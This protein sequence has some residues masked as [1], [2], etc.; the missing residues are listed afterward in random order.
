MP[1]CQT[2]PWLWGTRQ[3]KSQKFFNHVFRPLKAAYSSFMNY[4]SRSSHPFHLIGHL[5]VVLLNYQIIVK[6]LLGKVSNHHILKTRPPNYK[7]LAKVLQVKTPKRL[8]ARP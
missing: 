7:L 5:R 8:K 6:F 1:I 3:E 4:N 2:F